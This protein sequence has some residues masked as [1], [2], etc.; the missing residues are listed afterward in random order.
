M[1]SLPSC[2]SYVAIAR[3]ADLE[4]ALSHQRMGDPVRDA[5]LCAAETEHGGGAHLAD[6]DFSDAVAGAACLSA[7]GAHSSA[8]ASHSTAG[9]GVASHPRGAGAD[10]I[11]YRGD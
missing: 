8:E 5:D 9:A 7:D 4:P 2:F 3:Y 6:A 10:G 11:A 1:S